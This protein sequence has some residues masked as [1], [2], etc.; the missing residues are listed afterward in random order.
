MLARLSVRGVGVRQ[1][2]IFRGG[3]KTVIP[4]MFDFSGKRGMIGFF[5]K[6]DPIRTLA[7][8]QGTG[9]CSGQAN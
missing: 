7:T 9:S 4:G 6:F 8:A 3:C 5:V 1:R 2:S